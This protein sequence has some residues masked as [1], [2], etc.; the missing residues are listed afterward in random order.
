MR[1][2]KLVA[3]VLSMTAVLPAWGQDEKQA[4]ERYPEITFERST[5]DFG[6]F[7]RANGDKECYFVFTNTG[8]KELLILTA[9]ATCGCTKAF[10]PE[11]PILP[12]MKDSIRVT[13]KGSTQRVGKM[14]KT[15]ALTTNCK[16]NSAYLYI[17]GEMVEELVADRVK[18]QEE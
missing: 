15:I 12:G 8:D 7:D 4:D 13:Y 2:F 1:K 10:A 6:L 17:M 11:G 14:K 3:L 16:K 5:K 18:P 9:T